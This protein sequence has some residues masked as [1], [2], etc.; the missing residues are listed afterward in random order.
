MSVGGNLLMM[1]DLSV[2]IRQISREKMGSEIPLS[3]K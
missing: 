3:S 1:D 2:L